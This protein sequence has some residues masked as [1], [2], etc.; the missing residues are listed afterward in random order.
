[1][2]PTA[3]GFRAEM[4]FELMDEYELTG[5]AQCAFP[6]IETV[7]PWPQDLTC[8]TSMVAVSWQ[9]NGKKQRGLKRGGDILGGVLHLL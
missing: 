9:Q 7:T 1:M 4:T 5:E 8:M 2:G 3:V 6:A